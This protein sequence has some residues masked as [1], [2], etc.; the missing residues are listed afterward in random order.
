[1][2][3]VGGKVSCPWAPPVGAGPRGFLTPNLRAPFPTATT[4]ILFLASVPHG[5]GWTPKGPKRLCLHWIQGGSVPHGSLEA[6]IKVPAEKSQVAQEHAA[7]TLPGRV[8]KSRVPWGRRADKVTSPG[9]KQGDAVHSVRTCTLQR[10][11]PASTGGAQEGPRSYCS[12]VLS[13]ASR[14]A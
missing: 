5:R 3:T 10:G 6:P 4:F 13:Q 9:D 14:G 7:D 11:S 12:C 1:M 2:E 8:K